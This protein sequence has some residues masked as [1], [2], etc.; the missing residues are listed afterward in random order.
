MLAGDTLG[1]DVDGD[2]LAVSETVAVIPVAVDIIE[3]GV[4]PVTAGVVAA[5]TTIEVAVV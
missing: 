3:A 5:E 1:E 2:I 4:M